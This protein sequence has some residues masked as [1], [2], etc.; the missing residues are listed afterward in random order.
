MIASISGD[1]IIIALVSSIPVVI[2]LRGL[3]QA[4]SKRYQR[5]WFLLGKFPLHRHSKNGDIHYP[6][7]VI[8][9]DDVEGRK[10]GES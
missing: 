6:K 8:R 7:G 10:R 3:H 9:E 1:T 4:N 5:L 2:T